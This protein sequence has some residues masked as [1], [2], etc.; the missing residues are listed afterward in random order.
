MWPQKEAVC[1]YV[2]QQLLRASAGR[3]PNYTLHPLRSSTALCPPRGG[4]GLKVRSR[5]TDKDL[6]GV[7]RYSLY[8]DT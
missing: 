3:L 2:T 4:S 8:S 7:I 1:F 5:A 6:S